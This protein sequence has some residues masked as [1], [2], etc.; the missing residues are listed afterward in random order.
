[1]NMAKQTLNLPP[2]VGD[3]KVSIVKPSQG[4]SELFTVYAVYTMRNLCSAS[5]VLYILID[6]KPFFPFPILQ[7][8]SKVHFQH[9]KKQEQ[10]KSS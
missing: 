6:G 7:H 4:H 3:E 10:H 1:M 2:I 5:K 9:N 8:R